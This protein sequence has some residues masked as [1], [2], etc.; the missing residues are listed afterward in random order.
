VALAAA[1][2]EELLVQVVLQLL[3]RDLLAEILLEP[4]TMGLAA[5]AVLEPLVEVGQ[6]ALAALEVLAL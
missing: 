2:A 4:Q 5:A 3:G 1:L 6:E